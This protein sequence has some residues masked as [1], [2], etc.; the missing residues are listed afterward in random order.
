MVMVIEMVMVRSWRGGQIESSSISRPRVC[1]SAMWCRD[2]FPRPCRN[3]AW[4]IFEHGGCEGECWR[5][6]H[7]LADSLCLPCVGSRLRPCFWSLIIGPRLRLR[8]TVGSPVPASAGSPALEGN[9]EEVSKEHEQGS[10]IDEGKQAQE[11]QLEQQKDILRSAS[12]RQASIS[13]VNSD[14]AS[15]KMRPKALSLIDRIDSDPL[16][17]STVRE[18]IVQGELNCVLARRPVSDSFR[19]HAWCAEVLWVQYTS[20]RMLDADLRRGACAPVLSRPHEQLHLISQC[21]RHLSYGWLQILQSRLA[22]CAKEVVTSVQ[23]G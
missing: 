3:P 6:E 15:T 4:L 18:K 7:E 9:G 14:S 17:W 20:R 1:V 2:C 12:A 23:H 11:D 8:S 16:D 22:V 5:S 10:S 13:E 21:L 19:L